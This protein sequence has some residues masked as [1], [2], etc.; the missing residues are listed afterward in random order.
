MDF[1]HEIGQQIISSWLTYAAFL[2]MRLL[3][4]F[5]INMLTAKINALSLF[6]TFA[7]AYKLFK[8]LQLS[9]FLTRQKQVH[10]PG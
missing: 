5:A 6:I 1:T 7:E 4:F 2:K 3:S 10:G 9:L 8:G